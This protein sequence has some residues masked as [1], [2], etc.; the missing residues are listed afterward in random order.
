MIIV[1]A[2]AKGGVRKTTT[3]VTV[4]HGLA[5]NN[6][7]VLIGD[8]D[9][10]GNAAIALGQDPGPEM[11]DYLTGDLAM[12][13]AIRSA[14][15]DGPN[16][17][18]RPNLYLVRGNSRLRRAQVT[19]QNEVH[20]VAEVQARIRAL[21]EGYSYAVFDTAPSGLFQEVLI[22]LADLLIIPTTLEELPVQGMR[23]TLQMA[24]QLAPAAKVII[25]PTALDKRVGEHNAQLDLLKRA[26]T[27]PAGP[28]IAFPI[29]LRAAVL[30]AVAAG[31]TVWEHQVANMRDI[32]LY[33]SC[34]INSI[35]EAAHGAQG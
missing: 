19:M 21:A 4:G 20:G 32:H 18:E 3:A 1:V 25:L 10:Q 33:Y 26:Y 8:L 28:Q 7:P 15:S 11:A 29:P 9:P 30:D 2:S 22:S 35:M 16:A 5:M 31:L 6:Q 27:D 23:M 24:S 34:L 17:R 13:N 14:S 12:R